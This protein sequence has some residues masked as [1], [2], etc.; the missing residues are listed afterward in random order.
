M[1]EVKQASAKKATKGNKTTEL[2]IG[3]ASTKL[4]AA[5]NGFQS[6]VETVNKLPEVVQEYTLK[7]TDLEDKIGGLE[8]DF[9]NKTAQNKIDIE[10][11]YQ[12]D[13]LEFVGKWLKDNGVTTIDSQKLTDMETTIST[14]AATLEAS[15]KQA[16]ARATAIANSTATQN[17]KI[18]QLEHEKK[19]AANQAEI[20]QLKAQNAF[21]EKQCAGWE[22]ALDAERAAATERAKYGA[23]NTLN[24]GG[25]TQGR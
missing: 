12:A 20:A 17:L 11:Q 1:T 21:L 7:V 2:I 23:I 5:I 19:E 15:V 22:K 16:E 3:T 24:V 8:Q 9:K 25:T 4:T 18:Q 10:Q 13:K 14:N 6:A